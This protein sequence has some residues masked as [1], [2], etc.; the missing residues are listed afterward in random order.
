MNFGLYVHIPY[1]RSICPY[2]AFATAPLHRAEPERFLAALDRELAA[3]READGPWARPVT[4]YVGG[5]TPTA[6]DAPTLRRFLQWLRTSFDR[7]AVREWTV[8]ANPEGLTDE[9]LEILL[10]AG[11]PAEA[12]QCAPQEKVEVLMLARRG[13]PNCFG[14]CASD[15]GICIGSCQ[16]NNQCIMQ[17]QQ[18]YSRCVSRC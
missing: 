4:I 14:W 9:K 10:E 13:D 18:Q 3:I 1:C 5:G 17:C 8:E 16:G 7:S 15:Q 6:L 11:L 2:C 12:I